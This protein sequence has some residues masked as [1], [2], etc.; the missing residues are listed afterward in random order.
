MLRTG[1]GVAIHMD[2]VKPIFSGVASLDPDLTELRAS[3]TLEQGMTFKQNM[4][5]KHVMSPAVSTNNK[6]S[7]Q[8]RSSARHE[9]K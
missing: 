3:E 6:C 8:L 5:S 7:I 4:Q 9:P 2:Q 1:S